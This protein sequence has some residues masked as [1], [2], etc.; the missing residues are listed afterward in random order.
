[1]WVLYGSFH[2]S[3]F[4]RWLARLLWYV[5]VLGVDVCERVWRRRGWEGGFL[6]MV[7]K[8]EIVAKVSRQVYM[9]GM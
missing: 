4:C 1:M 9:T 6:N 8:K 2:N 5:E 3:R 7:L